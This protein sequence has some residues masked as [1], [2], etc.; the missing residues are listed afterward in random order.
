MTA[1]DVRSARPDQLVSG[2]KGQWEIII[3]LEVHAQDDF[4]AKRKD[5][6]WQ[7]SLFS[8]SKGY[9]YLYDEMSLP[10]LG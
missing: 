2:D 10:R 9:S 7:L 6:P 4:W 1:L 5:V 3:G 8:N